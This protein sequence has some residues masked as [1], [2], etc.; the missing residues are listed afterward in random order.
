M[1]IDIALIGNPGCGLTTL[2]NQMTGGAVHA[3]HFST[4]ENKTKEG[5]VK[6]H[7][8]V[9]LIELPGTYSLSAYSIDDVATREILLQGKPDVIVN[10]IDAASFERNLYLTLQLMELEL[11]MRSEERR[12][13]KEC[14]L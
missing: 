8:D 6:G 12:V 9:N 11:P 4:P 14:R 13:G 2:F 5:P 7:K 10:V 3:G 1:A